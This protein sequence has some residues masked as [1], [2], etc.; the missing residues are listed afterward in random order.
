[1]TEKRCTKICSIVSESHLHDLVQE[2]FSS[3]DDGLRYF[4]MQQWDSCHVIRTSKSVPG[5]G[6]W[7]QFRCK[8]CPDPGSSIF[9]YLN[10]CLM[11]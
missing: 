6:R 3:Y 1:M 9:P 5:K 2:Y 8:I 10:L 7:V 11:P 4:F